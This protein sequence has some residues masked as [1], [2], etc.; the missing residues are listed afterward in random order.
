MQRYSKSLWLILNN[1][2]KNRNVIVDFITK[3]P[4]ELRVQIN[5][6]LNRYDDYKMDTLIAK[7]NIS[8]QHELTVFSESFGGSLFWA[9]ISLDD[10]NLRLGLCLKNGN[11][12]EDVFQMSLAPDISFKYRRLELLEGFS[13]CDISYDSSMVKHGEKA[14]SSNLIEVD[15]KLVKGTFGP[16]LVYDT[17]ETI[18]KKKCVHTCLKRIPKHLN[19]YSMLNTYRFD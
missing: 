15:Y 8:N 11:S 12:Y 5:A 10:G 18:L 3:I 16:V 17:D 9:S 14:N 2:K 6:L 1:D 4:L 13:I 19:I 7:G